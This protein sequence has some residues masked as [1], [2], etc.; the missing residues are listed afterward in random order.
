VIQRK[1]FQKYF[2]WAF[3]TLILF[4]LLGFYFTDF[5]MKS[6]SPARHEMMPPV[7]IARLVDR[8]NPTDKVKAI[9]ELSSF[10]SNRQKRREPV[11]I[12]SSGQ[13]LYPG[14]VI[15]PF[16][17]E[18]IQKPKA[19]Y[20]FTLI[21]LAQKQPAPAFRFLPFIGGHGPPPGGPGGRESSALI[22]LSG[23]P[24]TYL[25]IQP[26]GPPPGDRPP[27]FF[28]FIGFASLVGS[29]LLGVAA[30]IFLIYASISKNV[31]LADKVLSELQKG[32]LKARFPIH[33]KDEF[34]Q[35]M[36]RFNRMAEEIENLVEHLRSVEAAR[37]KLL[38][39]LA[40]DL[41]TPIAS[42]KS[43][44]ET[45]HFKK[46]RLAFEVQNELMELSLQEVEYFERLVEDLLFLAQVNEPQ[47][48]L[49]REVLSLESLL[50][51]EAENCALRYE[52]NQNKIN[53][54]I[55]G[56]LSQLSVSGDA[57]LLRRLFRNALENS[58]S[59]AKSE[60]KIS[61]TLTP[62]QKIH[63]IIDDDGTGFSEE[64]LKSFGERRLSRKLDTLHKGRVSVGLGSVVMRTI[65]QAHRGETKASNRLSEDGATLGARVEI[66]LPSSSLVLN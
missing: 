43:L 8:L 22:R 52:Q 3:A 35:A 63:I 4:L 49:K 7:F 27:S 24:A 1:L 64:G 36:I 34:G 2:T 44:L 19:A 12:D 54:A 53:L 21:P 62:D 14:G 6:L 42:L 30:A 51:E 57:I 40:H 66:L 65:A 33:R 28:P 20:E 48:Q 9:Q 18:Q 38:Q 32:N 56:D 50:S 16:S 31:K 47:Y 26:Q 13:V 5:L 46:D 59:F 11:L 29:L 17:W 23:E 25:Y 10:E 15:L 41:R 39:E 45:L 55:L 37:T 60:V 61:A 58:F